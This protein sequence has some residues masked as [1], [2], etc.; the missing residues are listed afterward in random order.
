VLTQMRAE[1]FDDRALTRPLFEQHGPLST[2][3]DVT[4]RSAEDA[5]AALIDWINKI[6]PAPYKAQ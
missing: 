3:L 1:E 6:A 2:R 4:H 5:A